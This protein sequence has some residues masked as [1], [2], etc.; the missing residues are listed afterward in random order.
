MIRQQRSV[1]FAMATRCRKFRAGPWSHE[2]KP[3]SFLRRRPYHGRTQGEDTAI[4]VHVG[5]EVDVVPVAMAPSPCDAISRPDVE[6]TFCNSRCRCRR[7][8]GAFEIGQR[9]SSQERLPMNVFKCQCKFDL[10]FDIDTLPLK[11][12]G[13]F[14]TAIVVSRKVHV[15]PVASSCDEL[16]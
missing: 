2:P 8:D 3:K 11:C 15:R 13:R 6:P 5:A 10:C 9:S 12:E 16:N 7:V 4:A 14:S 1:R